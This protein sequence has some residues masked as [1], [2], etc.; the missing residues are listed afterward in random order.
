MKK[1]DRMKLIINKQIGDKTYSFEV[2][3]RNLYECVTESQ[4]LSFSDVPKCGICES[5]KL[6]LN[7]RLAQGKYKYV[8]IKCLNCKAQLTFGNKQEDADVYYLR[9]K[10]DKTYD[11]KKFEENK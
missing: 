11:W 2:E 8:E 3:G 7:A 6:V 5:E 10:E 1:G 9:K 4:K